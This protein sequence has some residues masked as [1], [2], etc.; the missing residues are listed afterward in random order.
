MHRPFL[1]SR[2]LPSDNEWR[3]GTAPP[4]GLRKKARLVPPSKWRR[5]VLSARLVLTGP[6]QRRTGHHDEGKQRTSPAAA[7][8]NAPLRCRGG[9]GVLGRVAGPTLLMLAALTCSEI[10]EALAHSSP[11]GGSP[12]HSE[13]SRRN[14]LQGVRSFGYQLQN[15]QPVQ[16]ASSTCLLYVI[17]STN[18]G[19]RPFT[20]TEV[21]TMR[22]L[23]GGG[24]RLLLAYLSIG[25]AESYRFYWHSDWSSRPPAWLGAE[26]DDWPG[27]F[28]VRFWEPD[29][30]SL[31]FG[32]PESFVHRIVTAGFDGVY[33]DRVDAY[34][35]WYEERS[36]GEDD[37]RE[38]VERLATY[39]RQ[40][41]P[42]FLI[43]PQN[44]EKLLNE[45]N[46]MSFIDGIGKE[47]L[48]YGSI[49]PGEP[50]PAAEIAESIKRLSLAR[51]IGL[52]VFLIEYTEDPESRRRVIAESG[53][54]GFIPLLAHRSLDVPSTCP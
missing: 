50:T 19:G 51:S 17:D 22:R 18:N 20:R 49:R 53:A 42:D 36:S 5:A 14:A 35:H 44:G 30:Q 39:A 45:K 12:S 40:L 16:I 38:F 31:I 4:S 43:V 27:N 24:R 9:R 15:V 37:M 28:H 8:L 21:S 32:G 54:L 52:P 25:E 23:P 47:D 13:A 7:P 11:A 46:Y 48:Y 6:L 41:D 1:S 29:W 10:D 26:N 2:H 3:P 34:E 33:L